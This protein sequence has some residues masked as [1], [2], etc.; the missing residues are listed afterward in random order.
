M[1]PLLAAK[2]SRPAGLRGLQT[3][4]L[5][6][7]RLQH[8][9]GTSAHL[10]NGCLCSEKRQ[11][12]QPLTVV[13]KLCVSSRDIVGL[14]FDLLLGFLGFFFFFVLFFAVMFWGADPSSCRLGG[15]VTSNDPDGQ[16]HESV[17]AA[18][19]SSLR[20]LAFQAKAF[21]PTLEPPKWGA[22]PLWQFLRVGWAARLNA[23]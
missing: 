21:H 1:H 19:C 22:A 5:V 20:R 8:L 6:A 10:P 15:D 12:S 9:Q 2:E 13:A 17:A 23:D 18:P 3:R 16:L 7:A 11:S 4:S 14:L